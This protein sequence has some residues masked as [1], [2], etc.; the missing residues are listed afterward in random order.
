MN[1]SN[2]SSNYIPLNN[3]P[4]DVEM[5][6]IQPRMVCAPQNNNLLQPQY[7]LL[8]QQHQEKKNNNKDP[9][10][11]TAFACADCDGECCSDIFSWICRIPNHLS[12]PHNSFCICCHDSKNHS[13]SGDANCCIIDCLHNHKCD[14]NCDCNCDGCNCDFSL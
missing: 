9:K 1:P 4:Q 5:Q 12:C 10:G 2:D 13:E 14:C 8:P 11:D 7:Y 3:R 6:M